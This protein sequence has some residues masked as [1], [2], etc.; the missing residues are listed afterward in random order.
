MTDPDAMREDESFL[1]YVFRILGDRL[2][3]D[4]PDPPVKRKWDREKSRL[5]ERC[6]VLAAKIA[7]YDYFID[8]H[9][10]KMTPEKWAKYD[11][12][13]QEQS[14]AKEAWH[15]YLRQERIKLLEP[16][17]EEKRRNARAGTS[18]PVRKE[19]VSGDHDVL[20]SGKQPSRADRDRA[21]YTGADSLF[22]ME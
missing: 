8:K 17:E 3:D 20:A 7:D 21:A 13:K 19:R 9:E 12:V 16:P 10:D 4:V 1:Q 11:A 5:Y 22:G 6:K 15:E 18:K 14:E 2:V